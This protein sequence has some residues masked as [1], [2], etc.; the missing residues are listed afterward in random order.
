M[1]DEVKTES[2]TEDVVAEGPVGIGVIDGLLNSLEAKCKLT[3]DVN[4]RL[5]HLK[6]KTR[7]DC[8]LNE[9]VWVTLEEEVIFKSCWLRLVAVDDEV[10]QISLS[11]H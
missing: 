6:R 10:R 1:H 2:R 3:S 11:Q 8:T 9:L 7:D 5:I 4:E